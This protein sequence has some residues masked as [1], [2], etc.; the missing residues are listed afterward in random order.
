MK[1]ISRF[2]F[3]AWRP[4]L[5]IAT[6]G[7]I[8]YFLYFHN[9]QGLLPGYASAERAS[10]Q[11]A[12]TWAAIQQNPLN[13]PYK[14]AVH[15]LDSTTHHSLVATRIAAALGGIVAVVTF[16]CITR[17]WYGF[18]VGFLSTVLFA[19]SAGF[20]HAARLGTPQI[21]QMGVVIL[22]AMLVWHRRS[23]RLHP[24][25]TYAVILVFGVLLYVPGM[26]WFE[27]IIAAVIVT[28]V[29]RHWNRS[30]LIHRIVWAVLAVV[31]LAPLVRALLASPH[32]AFTWFGLPTTI[33]SIGQ[34]PSHILQ[35]I[36][37]I[38]VRSDGTPLTW[39]GHSPL[40][41]VVELILAVIGIYVY[42]ERSLRSIL[43]TTALIIAVILIS[44][45]G[46]VSIAYLVPLLYL[47]VAGGIKHFLDEWLN[48]FPRNPIA[49]GFGISI[50]IIM[51][52]FSVF[53]HL[54]SYFVAWPHNSATKQ[55]FDLPRQD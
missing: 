46:G 31:L 27:G 7:L 49:R 5:V 34:I 44:L 47:L 2:F 3:R 16:F 11:S 21:L 30:A 52:S 54:R 15:L 38:G 1:T 9:L 32:L 53:Y 28:R 20:L 40:L 45:G 17:V 13:A 41:S 50:V 19:T 10:M 26:V 35:T 22:A 18:R 37:S 24:W 36:L 6:L 23:P 12:N 42:L 55:V 51:L 14:I 43:L 39:L 4:S 29:I 25:L 48:V 8:A 33:H